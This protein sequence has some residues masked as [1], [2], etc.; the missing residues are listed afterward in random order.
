MTKRITQLLLAVVFTT[1]FNACT[2]SHPSDTVSL[3]TVLQ[4]SADDLV[5]QAID[6]GEVG[7]Q[8]SNTE[9]NMDIL[10][11]PLLEARNLTPYQ[12]QNRLLLIFAESS[13]SPLYIEQIEEYTALSHELIDRDMLWFHLFRTGPNRASLT[14]QTGNHRAEL[15]PSYVEEGH[16]PISQ[17]SDEFVSGLQGRYNLDGTAFRV[18]LI[19]KDGGVK[20]N[21][22]DVVGP[23]QLFSLIDAMPMRQQEMRQEGQ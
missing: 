10:N 7:Y 1:L 14:E 15:Y 11:A 23:E 12:W 17:L 21:S 19:G 8:A 13:A 6:D 4:P 9:M 5:T 18:L 16:Q 22:T 2:L 3:D 20:L